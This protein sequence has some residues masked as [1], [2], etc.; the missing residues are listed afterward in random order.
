MNITS[1]LD[2]KAA[3]Q[4]EIIR[5][6]LFQNGQMSRQGLAKQVNLTTTA[7][8]VYLADIV[9]ICQPLGENFQLSDEQGQ[10]ILDFSSDINLDKILQSYLEKS[11]AYQILI[12][13]FEHKKFSIFQLT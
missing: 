9:Y 6:L 2:K 5:Q 7:L 1:L 3:V 11:L 4:I 12:F 10:I 8:K 13:I